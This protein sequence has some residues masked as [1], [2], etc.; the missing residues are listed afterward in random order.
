MKK[1]NI[2]IASILLCAFLLISLAAIA[3]SENRSIEIIYKNNDSEVLLEKIDSIYDFAI[4][5]GKVVD[6]ESEIIIENCNLGI[7]KDT[8]AV[9]TKKQ[10]KGK[11]EIRAD[12]LIISPGFIDLLTYDPVEIGVKAKIADGVTSN[13]CMHGGTA[14]AELW[15]SHWQ[16]MRPM[17]NYGASFAVNQARMILG[18]DIYEKATGEKLK[19]LLEMA[20]KALLDGAL[21]VS[22]SLEYAP[23][24]KEEEIY[25]LMLLAK[26][27]DAPVFFHV[28]YSD[29]EPPGT[30]IEALDEVISF[31]RSTLASIH[32]DHI[33]ST[34]GTF[35][36]SQ[37]LQMIKSAR[38]EGLDITACVYPYDYWGTHLNTARFSKGWQQRFRINYSDLQVAGTNERLTK[39]TFEKYRKQGKLVVAYAIP[40]EELI[41]AMQTD[42]VMIGSDAILTDELNNHPRACGTY[43]RTIGYY[44]RER[45]VISLMEAIKKCS[46]LPAKRMEQIAPIF[47]KLGRLKVGAY[48]DV[49]IFNYNK[50]IDKATPEKTH[51]HS[52]GIEYVIISGELVK[53]DNVIYENIRQGKQIRGKHYKGKK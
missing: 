16:R 33:H 50:I 28:R 12:G 18:I 24:C 29:M 41:M 6:P 40:E 14:K 10:I 46:Y 34:G 51:L 43:A 31:A 20:E 36:M 23:G 32:I 47:K 38:A 53:K 5:N 15:Y 49:T 27:Y 19:K 3:T 44:S 39:E 11:K 30:N 45:K 42:F 17:V 26:K 13:I 21:G 35:S 52:E 7:N 4:L 37:S 25:E 9:I 48:A 1:N 8:I 22:F 2:L